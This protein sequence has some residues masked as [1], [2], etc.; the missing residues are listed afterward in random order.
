[1]FSHET[2]LF[3]LGLADREPRRFSVTLAAG[4]NGTALAKEGI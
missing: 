2:A 3:L 4:S 1:V